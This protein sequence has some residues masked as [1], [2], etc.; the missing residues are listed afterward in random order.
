MRELA[1]GLNA[2]LKRLGLAIR[3]PVSGRP[4]SLVAETK[5]AVEPDVCRYRFQESGDRG[6]PKRHSACRT[7]P[8]LSLT[9]LPAR[10]ESFASS[11]RGQDRSRDEDDGPQ[12]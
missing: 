7:L 10:V 9:A 1:T 11:Y 6:R 12:R 4:S 2:Q 5:S 8:P 3:C